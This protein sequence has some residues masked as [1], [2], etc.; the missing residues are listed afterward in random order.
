[1]ARSHRVRRL[2]R[3]RKRI[4][5]RYPVSLLRASGSG[6]VLGV[7][8][9]MVISMML[10]AALLAGKLFVCHQRAQLAADTSALAASAADNGFIAGQSACTA[11][12]DCAE[13]NHATLMRCTKD[14]EADDMKVTVSYATHVP[15]VPLLT[16]SSRAGPIPCQ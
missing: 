11:A 7:M 5:I 8:L 15:F 16:V 9:I 10:T 12:S 14:V 2:R 1:M 3:L 13:L 4:D 6:T